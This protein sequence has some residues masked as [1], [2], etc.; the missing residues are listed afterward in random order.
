MLKTS[1]Q[2]VRSQKERIKEAKTAVMKAA[3]EKKALLAQAA[4]KKQKAAKK[5]GAKADEAPPEEE[6]PKE[7]IATIESD[8]GDLN[9]NDPEDFK[10]ALAKECPRSFTFGPIE[11]NDLSLDAEKFP[12][13]FEEERQRI[14]DCLDLHMQ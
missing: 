9:L 1:R 5:K 10:K 4:L 11:F 2:D 13:N 3:E 8:D 6:A 12:L 14:V 7:V